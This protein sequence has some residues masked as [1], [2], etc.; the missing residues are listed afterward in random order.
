[1]LCMI[2]NLMQNISHIQ[3][4]CENIMRNTVSSTKH[5]YGFE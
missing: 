2:D 5:Y 3:I 1:M 4:E